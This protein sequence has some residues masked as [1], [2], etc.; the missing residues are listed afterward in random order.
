M[1]ICRGVSAVLLLAVLAFIALLALPAAGQPATTTPPTITSPPTTTGATSTSTAPGAPQTT[2]PTPGSGA[3]TGAPGRGAVLIVVRR[4]TWRQAAA[5]A[6]GRSETITAGLIST[7]PGDASLAARVL[8]LAAGRQVDAAPLA[9]GTDR[10]AIERMRAANPDAHFGG[11]PQVRVVA[12]SG[13]EAAGLIGLGPTGEPPPVAPLEV[14]GPPLPAA[15]ELLVVAVPDAAGLQRVLE[16]L[17]PGSAP[18]GTVGGAPDVDAPPAPSRF[19]I[20]GLEPPKGRAHTA[21]FIALGGAPGLVTSESTRR[22]GLVAFQDLR[23][24]LAGSAAGTDGVTIRALAV[25]DP[26]GSVGRLDRQVAS[27]VAARSLAIPL[28]VVV[29]SLA[30]A[31]SLLALLLLRRPA[32]ARGGEVL[33]RLARTL[34]LITLALPSAYLVASMVAP[35]SW[36]LWLGLGLGAAP[37]LALATWLVSRLSRRPWSRRASSKAAK[38]APANATG[39][40]PAPP[41]GEVTAARDGAGNG[42]SDDV[43]TDVGTWAAPALLGALLAALII[44]DLLLGGLALSRPLLGNSAFDGERFFGLGNGYFAHALAGLLLVV[45]F[46]Q[47]SAATAAT[48]LAALALADGL[49][50]LGADVGGALTAMLTAAAAW[51]LLRRRRWSRLRVLLVVTGAVAVAVAVAFGVGPAIGRV[52]HGSR[53][54]REL[55]GDDPS[56]ALRAV[57]HQLSGN[58]GLLAENFW[59]WWG[60][61]LVIFAAV[62]SLRPPSLLAGVPVPIRRAVGVGAIGSLL[63]MVLNDTG[64]TAAAGSGLALVVTLAWCALERSPLELAADGTT[65]AARETAAPARSKPAEQAVPTRNVDNDGRR[66]PAVTPPSGKPAETAAQGQPA[67]APVSGRPVPAPPPGSRGGPPPADRGGPPPAGTSAKGDGRAHQ[68]PNGRPN[69]SQDAGARQDRGARREGP[70]R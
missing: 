20:V 56:A 8:S 10:A 31:A 46:R 1:R 34:L 47:P 4:L 5:A 36:P 21:P 32:G 66:K 37:V 51:L 49:P 55:L 58:F 3:E 53:I 9:G 60:P 19:V 24:T 13:L 25:V 30:L 50:I 67:D 15:G 68:D 6:R 2:A 42:S 7:L 43:A 38:G 33:R 59:A 57:R 54:A 48:V 23:P 14:T 16:Q 64:V 52:D 28:A 35:P 70:G 61:L 26:L 62:A 69:G 18:A 45:A 63:L 41:A 22:R 39:K 40:V 12:A 27:L 65:V 44:V 29:G 17:Q 11:L